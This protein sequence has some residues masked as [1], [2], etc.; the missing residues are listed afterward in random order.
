[1]KRRVIQIQDLIARELAGVFTREVEFP[2]GAFPSIIKVKVSEDLR[3]ALVWIGVV[4][5]E[6]RPDVL[7]CLNKNIYHIQAFLNKRLTMKFPPRLLFKIDTTSDK[8]QRI[9]ELVEKIHK[10]DD[11]A[12]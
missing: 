3:H 6:K 10:E 9:E 2:L 4:P 8:V 12:K 1:M 5:P 11:C 7:E